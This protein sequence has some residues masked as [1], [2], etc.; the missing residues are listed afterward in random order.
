MLGS[1]SRKNTGSFDPEQVAMM[2][3][4]IDR[5][6]DIVCHDEQAEETEAR[7]L[8][9]LCV[10]SEIRNGEENYTKLVNR[11]I[12]EFRRQHARVLLTRRRISIRSPK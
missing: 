1:I 2:T 12:A 6:W 3:R 9:S 11:S 7:N 10:L 8:L 5:A 4:V